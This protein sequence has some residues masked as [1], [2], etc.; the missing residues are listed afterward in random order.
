M[1]TTAA[2]TVLDLLREAGKAGMRP[3]DIAAQIARPDYALAALL[4][5]GDIVR[6]T[7]GSTNS[8]YY[9]TGLQPAG[10]DTRTTVRHVTAKAARGP[11]TVPDNVRIV[12]GPDFRDTRYAA[13]PAIA[14]RGQITRD[15]QERRLA[16][17]QQRA[18]KRRGGQRA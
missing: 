4:R 16:D 6:V 18:P 9:V 14:G 7:R 15:W 5:S 17:A 10:A 1:S 8:R 2:A 3:M 12:C 13:D 11:A